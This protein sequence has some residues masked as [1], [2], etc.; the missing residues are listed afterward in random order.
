M[1]LWSTTT[2]AASL[3]SIAAVMEVAAASQTAW[4]ASN[5]QVGGVTAVRVLALLAADIVRQALIAARV[6]LSPSGME[7]ESRIVDRE[8]TAVETRS[9]LVSHGA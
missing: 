2:E 6:S 8:L 7:E 5:T 4:A 9:A 1:A 3:T